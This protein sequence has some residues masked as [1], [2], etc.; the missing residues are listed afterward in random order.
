M[1]V[2]L[3]QPD[4]RRQCA[5]Q[6]SLFGRLLPSRSLL[7][8]A[9]ILEASGHEAV[10]LD[11]PAALAAGPDPCKLDMPEAMSSLL[12]AEKFDAVGIACYTQLR[13]EARELALA[14]KK[15]DRK[16]PVI[17]GGP[18]PMLLARQILKE[19]KEVDYVCLGAADESL[20]SLV[21]S[22]AGEGGPH[23]R[24][25]NIAFRSGPFNVRQTGNPSYRAD[26]AEIPAIDY[27]RHLDRVGSRG[28]KRAYIM[29]ARGCRHLCNFCSQLWKK[30]F[31]APA[32]KVADE[33]ER[34][35][36]Q[37]GAEEIVIY[38]DCFGMNQAHA[39]SV[40]EALIERKLGVRLQAVTRLDAVD[41]SWVS[42]FKEA[43]GRDLLTGIESGSEQVRKRM[44]K[45]MDPESICR[46]AEIA[47]NHGLRLGV[48]LI[49]GF[50]AEDEAAVEETRR[51]LDKLRPSQVMS[52][53]FDVKPGDV[54]YRFAHLGGTLEEDDWLDNNRRLV[55]G[56]SAE[57]LERTAARCVR[58]D[59]A[60]TREVLMPE[61][62]PADFIL[63]IS[64]ER[65]EGLLSEE[66][67]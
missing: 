43:G 52:S 18:H 65:I 40:L 2:L 60:Y 53:V 61:H 27:T 51:L 25:R 35:A 14:A 54:F 66:G 24:I 32:A 6:E 38:D 47:R 13:K 64:P 26:L 56:M 23:F 63:G 3:V 59:R 19:W 58:F 37:C 7:E 57:E 34:L 16:R 42:L 22:L 11:P 45:H 29:T 44:N 1:R 55:N 48:F 15:N 31:L 28:F 5:D 10:V 41:E 62:D 49:F 39:R 17:L 8:L 33:A 20:P 46:G 4:Y 67:V 12:E 21:S 9:A 50:P 36:G 30:V